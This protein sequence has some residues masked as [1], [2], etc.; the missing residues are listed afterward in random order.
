MGRCKDTSKISISKN[1]LR[2]RDLSFG[3]INFRDGYFKNVTDSSGHT[4]RK[5]AESRHAV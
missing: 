4:Q 1:R 5:G 2:V 3:A